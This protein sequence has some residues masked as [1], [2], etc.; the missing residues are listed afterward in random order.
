MMSAQGPLTWSLGPIDEA[1]LRVVAMLLLF[2]AAALGCVNWY[3]F[4]ASWRN[5]RAG[6]Q[7]HYSSVHL[8]PQLLAAAAY[9]LASRVGLSWPPPVG[10]LMVAL[11]DVSLWQVVTWPVVSLY[12]SVA[13]RHGA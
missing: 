3:A 5:W 2:L 4:F 6:I 12:R 1:S 9:L 8:V 13:S 7:K 10:F 11:L